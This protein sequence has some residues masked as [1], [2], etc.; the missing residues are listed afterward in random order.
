MSAG[1]GLSF[2]FHPDASQRAVLARYTGV[3]RFAYNWV[4]YANRAGERVEGD[5]LR[6]RFWDAAS[7]EA[8]WVSEVPKAIA[9]T[10]L[11]EA[12]RELAACRTTP[13]RR[14]RYRRKEDEASVRL[15]GDGAFKV[16]QGGIQLPEVGKLMLSGTG[17]IASNVE[18]VVLARLGDEWFLRL[19]P[20]RVPQIRGRDRG[21]E[22]GGRR[23]D[24]VERVDLADLPESVT[25]VRDGVAHVGKAA[26][27]AVRGDEPTSKAT[28]GWEALD[29]WF[30]SS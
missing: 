11:R 20:E 30:A 21:R 7:R 29:R 28:T 9:E 26:T 25:L 13:G 12:E 2:R 19:P 27:V 18:A 23:S 22:G 17:R 10:A 14:P 8:P 15:D 3:S 4:L 6:T 5:E 1:D 24:P 16:G